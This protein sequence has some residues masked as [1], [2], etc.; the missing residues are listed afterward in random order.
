[1]ARRR[2]KQ[3][4]AM[5]KIMDCYRRYKLRTYLLLVIERFKYVNHLNYDFSFLMFFFAQFYLYRCY[6]S[7]MFVECQIWVKVC[8]GPKHPQF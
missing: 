6:V 7:G 1:M 3:L 2:V 8:S 4:R 5:Y